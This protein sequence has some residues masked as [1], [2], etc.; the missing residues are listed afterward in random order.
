MRGEGGVAGSQL[1]PW[2]IYNTNVIFVNIWRIFRTVNWCDCSGSALLYGRPLR[3]LSLPNP[4]S[5]ARIEPGTY[6]AANRCAIHLTTQHP[7]LATPPPIELRATATHIK[8]S[9]TRDFRSQFFFHESVSLGPLSIPLGPFQIFSKIRRDN[10]E[11][12]FISGVNDTG[13]KLFGGVNDTGDKFFG[14]VNDTS[15]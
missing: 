14:G 10:R 8:G 11:W 6:Q 5:L 3:Y 15:D 4:G 7:G 12:M 13:D 1:R 9:L 2:T